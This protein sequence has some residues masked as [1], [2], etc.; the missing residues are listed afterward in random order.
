MCLLFMDFSSSGPQLSIKNRLYVI[1]FRNESLLPGRG[2]QKLLIL[3]QGVMAALTFITSLA[4]VSFM[5][6][7]DALCIIFACPVVTIALSAV[8][9][10]DSINIAKIIAGQLLLLGVVLVCKPPFLFHIIQDEDLLTKVT[11]CIFNSFHGD[12]LLLCAAL[13]P[14]VL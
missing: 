6:V 10:R 11:V 8:L 12:I 5:A 7:P 14:S 4:C 9:L 13:P 3:V 2:K 1:I